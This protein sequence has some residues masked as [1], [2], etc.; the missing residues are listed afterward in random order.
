MKEKN[1]HLVGI[2]PLIF[3]SRA[4]LVPLQEGY[5]SQSGTT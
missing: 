5:I 3:D 4:Y 1:A 2:W